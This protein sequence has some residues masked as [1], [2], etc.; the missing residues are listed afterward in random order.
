M[1]RVGIIYFS[2][3][4]VTGQLARALME[5]LQSSG[6]I[7]LLEYHITGQEIIEGRFRNEAILLSLTDCQAIVFGSPTYMGGPAA[8]FKAFADATSEIWCDQAWSGKLAA[9]ITSGSAP[10]GDQS[11]TLHYFMTLASQHGMLWAGVDSALGYDKKDINRLGSQ[12]GVT[13]HSPDGLLHEVDRATAIYLGER[14][15]SLLQTFSN[16]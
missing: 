4:D 16:P 15:A 14:I 10:N 3:S 5:G 9:G 6:P 7:D 13:A 8:Q 12:P 1:K 11:N 2:K